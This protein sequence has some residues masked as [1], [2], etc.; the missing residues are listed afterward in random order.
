[1]HHYGWVGLALHEIPK[2]TL[3]KINGVA[4]GAGL[5]LALGCDLIVAGESARFSEIFV[6][7]GLAID[8]GGSWLLPRLVGLHKA[9]ELALLGDMLDAKEAERI[10]IVNRVVRIREADGRGANQEIIF[11]DLPAAVNHNGGRLRFGPDGMLYIGA[12][13]AYVPERAQDRSSPAGAILRLTPEGRVPDDNP[14]PGNPIWAMGLRNPNAL[15]F[16]PS[17]GAL[18]AG[19]EVAELVARAT[20]GVAAG[21]REVQRDVLRGPGAGVGD[22]QPEGLRL[23]KE[24]LFGADDRQGDQR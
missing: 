2:P 9:K 7:R 20:V 11:D 1:M 10:G 15:A 6:R 8:L 19:A 23:A 4:V 13:D 24:D 5:N 12:G 3:A 22:R 14:W 17:D 16:R 18:F 21:R